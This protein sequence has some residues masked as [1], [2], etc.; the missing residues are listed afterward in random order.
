[1]SVLPNWRSKEACR[2][3]NDIHCRWIGGWVR[4][5]R[6]ISGVASYRLPEAQ[7]EQV[8]TELANG[9]LTRCSYISTSHQNVRNPVHL[10]PPLWTRTAIQTS[11][12][13]LGRLPAFSPAAVP[14][15]GSKF[16]CISRPGISSTPTSCFSALWDCLTRNGRTCTILAPGMHLCLFPQLFSKRSTQRL[17]RKLLQEDLDIACQYWKEG[18]QAYTQRRSQRVRVSRPDGGGQGPVAQLGSRRV[19]PSAALVDAASPL[20]KRITFLDGRNRG[21][22]GGAGNVTVRGSASVGEQ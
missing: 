10:G 16:A 22:G 14:R 20:R 6:R 7:C 4:T 9:F 2:T 5:I 3:W 12:R 19:R 13:I 8:K 11:L 17:K 21:G 15:S 18:D 1:M